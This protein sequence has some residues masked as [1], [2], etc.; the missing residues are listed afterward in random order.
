MEKLSLKKKL[1]VI[2][3]YFEGLSY[4]EIAVKAVVGKGTVANVIV[5]V[6]AGRFPEFGNLPEQLDLL[7]ELAVDLKRIRLTP[8]Q[9]AVGVS[10]LSRLEELGVK[11]NEIE[12][13]SAL[14]QTLNTDDIDIQSFMRVG[15]ALEEVRESTGL[16]FE[17]LE[18]KAKELEESVSRLEPVA[19]QIAASQTELT[20]LE[21]RR[22]ILVEEIAEFNERNEILKQNV[23]DKEQREAV[24]SDHV[25]ALED[26]VQSADERLAT[27]RKDLKE[28]SG[29]GMSPDNLTAFTQRLKV[30]GQRHG[31]KPE[32]I[33]S[34]LMDELEQLGEGL[35]LDTI[36]KVKKQELRRI[37]GTVLKGKGESAAIRSINEKLRQERSGLKVVLSEE[38]RNITNNIVAINRTAENTTAQ[39][40]AVI[41]EER[42]QISRIFEDISTAT[43][44]TITE[45]K[46]NLRTG[47]GESISEVN[48]LKDQALEL[49]KQ[50]GQFDE[51]V[52]SNKWIKG[53]QSLINGDDEIE[54]DQMRVIGIAVGHSLLTWV[55]RHSEGSGVPWLLKSSIINL[56][57]ELERWKL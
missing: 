56:I 45:L 20:N 38:R 41:L 11:P 8:V 26:R 42:K 19:K 24:L 12:G 18:M 27:T 52:E 25:M 32:V 29:I 30:I 9:T 49:G 46:Q 13:F 31:M 22:E 57:G 10:V 15:L 1:L 17:E 37:E 34:K 7:R 51:L 55:D 33:C 2:R 23:K 21:A 36:T 3:L 43:K 14:C 47:V 5:E 35:G 44:N 48:K 53:L 4:D 6:K 39:L 54:S 28:L 50:L 40:E 16:S